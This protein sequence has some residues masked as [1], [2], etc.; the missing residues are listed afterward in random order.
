MQMSYRRFGTMIVTSTIVMFGLM[1]L[2]TY[3]LEHV[4]FSEMRTYMALLMGAAMAIIMLAFMLSMYKNM[5]ANIAI[6]A[7]AAIVFLICLWLIRSQATVGQV[8]Y[9]KAMIPHHSIAILTSRRAQITDPDVRRLADDIIEAQERE[10]A[11][12]RYLIRKL[13]KQP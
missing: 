10:I 3:A 1:Y 9:M 4:F 5:T 12:M 6:F 2:N 11:E 8:S 13:E 7:G